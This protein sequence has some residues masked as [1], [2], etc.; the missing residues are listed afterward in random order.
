M[1]IAYKMKNLTCTNIHRSILI[2]HY[3][4]YFKISFLVHFLTGS[5]GRGF[6][7]FTC[8]SVA[9][10][11]TPGFGYECYYRDRP[12]C[13]KLVLSERLID[14]S[15]AFVERIALRAGNLLRARIDSFIS[16]LDLDV[17]VCPDV[18]VPIRIGIGSSL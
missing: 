13:L 15:L 7:H 17:W 1:S 18:V 6:R 12:L 4:W 5:K 9:F 11:F 10:L 3:Q 8:D 2:I 14:G 16:D